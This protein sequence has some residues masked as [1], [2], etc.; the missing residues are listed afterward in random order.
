[1]TAAEP[2]ERVLKDIS[3]FGDSLKLLSGTKLDGKMSS[4]VEMAKLYASDAQ[5]YLDKGDILTAFS[6]ISYAHGL[7]DSILSLVGLK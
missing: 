5:S 1:M 7:M 4:V 3:M 6:C 2:K